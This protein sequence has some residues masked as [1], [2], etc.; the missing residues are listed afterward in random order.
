MGAGR[1]V[2]AKVEVRH[3]PLQFDEVFDEERVVALPARHRP[4][5]RDRVGI[6]ELDGED[7][8][9][10]TPAT[11]RWANRAWIRRSDIG[12]SADGC[13]RPDTDRHRAGRSA[14]GGTHAGRRVRVARRDG[15]GGADPRGCGQAR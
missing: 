6:A 15:I 11:L 2:T 5:G 4:A 9:D 13:P 12:R 8:C 10:I 7:V 14:E 3:A 1:R